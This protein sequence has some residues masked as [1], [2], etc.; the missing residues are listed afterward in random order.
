MRIISSNSSTQHHRTPVNMW[1][2]P[3]PTHEQLGLIIIIITM[4]LEW[5]KR[6]QI[7]TQLKPRAVQVS[8]D[9]SA[10]NLHERNL[11]W[12]AKACSWIVWRVG[13][14][15]LKPTDSKHKPNP[16]L[17]PSLEMVTRTLLRNSIYLSLTNKKTYSKFGLPIKTL[18]AW[19][20][21][22]FVVYKCRIH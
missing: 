14:W 8:R 1:T 20:H 17:G 11:L 2:P 16:S 21:E 9:R 4:H 5:H 3:R 7:W 19:L 12:P 18:S 15:T 13:H 22:E 6:L 10:A